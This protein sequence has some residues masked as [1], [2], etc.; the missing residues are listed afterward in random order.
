MSDTATISVRP[1]IDIEEEIHHVMQHYGPLINDRHQITISV[2]DGVVTVQG[3]TRVQTTTN[4]L[5]NHIKSVAGVV[6]LDASRLYNDDTI[7]LD[8]GHVIPPGVSVL[9]EYGAVILSGMLP[10]ETDLEAMVGDV[11]QVPGVRRVITS[12]IGDSL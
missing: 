4:Y 2:V 8:V 9:V 3:Y 5:L 12:F 11:V 1:D 10:A 7:R 6:A